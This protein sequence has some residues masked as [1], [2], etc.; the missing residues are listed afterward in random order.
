VNVSIRI[1][2]H[3]AE[4]IRA[5]HDWWLINRTKAPD[6][7]A[8]EL[9]RALDLISTLPD[10]GEPVAHP[11]LAGIRRLQ[12]GRIRYY[13]YYIKAADSPVVDVLALWHMSRGG[14]PPIA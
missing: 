1:A 11:D 4:Q 6:A 2:P 5:A 7:F 14:Q 10:A 3:A 9:E 12:L 13:L 8:E